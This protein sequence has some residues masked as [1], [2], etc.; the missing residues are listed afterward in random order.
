MEIPAKDLQR[1]WGVRPATLVH[2][3]A[4][5]AEEWSAYSE[6]GW[7]ESSLVWVEALPNKCDE[8]VQRFAQYTT[9]DVVSGIAWDTSD[10]LV[11]F[12]VMSNVQSSSAL[13]PREHLEVYPDIQVIEQLNLKTIR[14]DSVASIAAIDKIELICLDVQ[15]AE[16][17]ALAGL[18]VLIQQTMAVYSE[19]STRELYEGGHSFAEIDAWL[20]HQGFCLVDWQIHADGWGDALWLR[21]SPNAPSRLMR[22]LIRNLHNSYR[23][24]VRRGRVKKSRK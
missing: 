6:L 24:L 4:H 17:R 2:V 9:I 1:Y 3:G 5:E 14:L 20:S 23:R 15:G 7:G 16:L 8:L 13:A 22:R 11:Q 10:L 18:G 12:N 19:V 21:N